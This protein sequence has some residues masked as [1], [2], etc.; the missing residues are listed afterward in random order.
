MWSLNE[1]PILRGVARPEILSSWSHGLGFVR[2]ADGDAERIFSTFCGHGEVIEYQLSRSTLEAEFHHETLG[3][4]QV[5]QLP[6]SGEGIQTA[7]VDNDGEPD[8][9]LATGYA[10]GKAAIRIY[11]PTEQGIADNPKHVLDEGCAF[12]NSKF[13]V[14]DMRGDGSH[15]LIAWWSSQLAGG[16]SKII[17]YHLE[18]DGLTNRTVIGQGDA[19]TLW[20]IDGQMTLADMNRDG[21]SEVWFATVWAAS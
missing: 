15:D 1:F 4:R 14:G 7:D 9:C 12:A 16:A 20:P 18:P 19:G 3:W 6:A 2:S 5:G 13:L 8:L 11:K 10:D 21:N 17:R